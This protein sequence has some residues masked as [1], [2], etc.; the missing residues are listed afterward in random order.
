MNATTFIVLT[1][2]V[3]VAGQWAQ[4]KLITM[5]LVVGGTFLAIALGIMSQMNEK[6][7]MT[8]AALI[9]TTAVF[10]YGPDIVKGLGLTK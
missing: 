2:A 7:G 8:F 4:D 1:A 10:T 9:F 3:V 5:K 6:L